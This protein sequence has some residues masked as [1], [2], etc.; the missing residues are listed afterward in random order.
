M[1]C[2]DGKDEFR[3][4]IEHA[5]AFLE[6]FP[7]SAEDA[8][9]RFALAQAY[10]TWWSLNHAGL[11]GFLPP[12][13]GYREGADDARLRAIAL[14]TELLESEAGRPYAVYVQSRL[15]RLRLGVTSQQLHFY[16]MMC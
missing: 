4:V 5:R 14:Y 16:C 15:V 9:V 10:E 13:E 12:A 1:G 6:R 11:D 8:S 2:E 3:K 7:Q